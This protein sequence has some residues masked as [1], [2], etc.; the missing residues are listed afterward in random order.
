VSGA[1]L[2][3]GTDLDFLFPKG[4]AVF[5][6]GG[7]LAFHHGGPS[8]QEMIVPVITLRIPPSAVEVTSTSKVVLEGYPSVLTN[9]TFGMSISVAADFFSNER[10]SVRL[11][12]LAEGSE[13][14]RCGMALDAELD[15]ASGTLMLEPG[16]TANVAMMLTTDEFKKIRIIAQDPITDAVLAQS[17]DIDVKL[18]M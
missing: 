11:V 15:R 12:L 7:D 8:L 2:G 6:A 18:G 9:R 1:E 14:G 10:T 3:Y 4:L 13:V 16:K 17:G 5:R